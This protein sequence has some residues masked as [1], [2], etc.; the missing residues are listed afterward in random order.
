MYTVK[1][2]SKKTVFTERYQYFK[3]SENIL[4]IEKQKKVF[5]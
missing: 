3:K 2:L 5:Y 1:I 4:P